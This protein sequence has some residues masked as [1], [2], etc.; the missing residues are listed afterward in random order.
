[1][2]GYE[3]QC[4]TCHCSFVKHI[5]YER[6]GDEVIACP[7]CGSDDV[8]RQ[9]SRVRIAKSRDNRLREMKKWADPQKMDA[10]ESDP[11]EMG[12]A[13]RKMSKEVGGDMGDDF[14]E[15]VDRLEH[16]QS[17]AE[18]EESLPESPRSSKKE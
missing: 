15:V 1:M 10:L 12:K 6:Y 13:F 8:A 2:P 11:V 9:I 4:N 17:T 3:Y 14:N 16:G 7:A 5:P 18:I